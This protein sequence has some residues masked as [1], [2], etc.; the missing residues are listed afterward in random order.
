MEYVDG[1]WLQE[2]FKSNSS[3]F[4]AASD[5]DVEDSWP[6]PTPPSPPSPMLL[7]QE[8]VDEAEMNKL[9]LSLAQSFCQLT[10]KHPPLTH[11]I[12]VLATTTHKLIHKC[13]FI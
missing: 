6:P 3:H 10:S 9:D 5:R 2:G 8:T 1:G 11:D 12:S 13:G 4:T 7:D